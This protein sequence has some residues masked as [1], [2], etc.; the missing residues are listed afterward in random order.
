MDDRFHISRI[1]IEGDHKTTVATIILSALER[2]GYQVV[3]DVKTAKQER[4]V[5]RKRKLGLPKEQGTV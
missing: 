3:N 4:L 2:Y 1:Y 5:L